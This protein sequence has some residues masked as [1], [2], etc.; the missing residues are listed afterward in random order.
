MGILCAWCGK[1]ISEDAYIDYEASAT[2]DTFG[3][4]G[5]TTLE[6]IEMKCY[7]EN[8]PKYNKVIYKKEFDK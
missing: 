4:N 2:Y 1:E 3:A 7:N 5:G 8:C 6:T